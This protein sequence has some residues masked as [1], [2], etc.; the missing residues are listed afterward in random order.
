MKRAEMEIGNKSFMISV[1]FINTLILQAKDESRDA[2][3]QGPETNASP[4]EGVD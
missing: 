4:S 1:Y 3:M 2:F